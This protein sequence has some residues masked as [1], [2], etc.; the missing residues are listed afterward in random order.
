MESYLVQIPALAA[1]GRTDDAAPD[2]PGD[3]AVESGGCMKLMRYR[4]GIPELEWERPALSQNRVQKLFNELFTPVPAE[5][6][7][8]YP[9][10]DILETDKELVLRADLP[11]L[12]KD[13]VQLEVRE[14]VLVMK[15]EKL[16]K[17]DET[18]A[19]YRIVER[20]YGSFERFFTL[21][22]TVE[23][24]QIKAEFTNGVLEVRLPKT[25]KAVGRRVP[26]TV[27]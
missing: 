16:E 11:G 9:E 15:G 4:P 6:L 12:A 27:K 1:C 3:S 8:W 22:S 5:G 7:G 19:Q 14:G 21:P 25:A 20:S 24:E 23:P 17:K 13:D 18:N 2:A 10:V 26:I